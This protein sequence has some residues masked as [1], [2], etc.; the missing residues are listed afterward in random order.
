M[1]G[2][3]RIISQSSAEIL[4]ATLAVAMVAVVLGIRNG[5]QHRRQRALWNQLLEGAQGQNLEQM[6]LASLQENRS[7]AERLETAEQRL[8]EIE[9]H[10]EKSKR[11]LG[12]VRYDAFEDVGGGQSFA[13][14]IYDDNGDG[15]VLNGLIGRADCRVYCK[16]LVGGR[17]DRTL[18]QE[19]RRAIEDALG[20]APKSVVSS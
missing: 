10:A 15:V 8:R 7:L 9:R 1:E 14:A 16:P 2:L 5:L 20:R 17:S 11:H 19:E 12:L 13:L 3:L 4:L 6:L 18:S